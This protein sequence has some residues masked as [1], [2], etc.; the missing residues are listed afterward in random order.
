M[1]TSTKTKLL[2]LM[3]VSTLCVYNVNA[4]TA[5]S[6]SGSNTCG[7]GNAGGSTN[8]S[9][10][11]VAG[12]SNTTGTKNTATGDSALYSNTVSGNSAFGFCSMKLNTTGVSNDATGTNSM[13][14][15]STGTN[16]SAHGINAMFKNTT[17]SGN[18]STG[19]NALYSNA[20]SNYST[21]MGYETLENTTGTY[22]TGF[23]TA[24][25][26]T[27]T[28]GTDNTFVGGLAD[29]N[30]TGY[31]DCGSFGY[32]TVVTASDKI[33][34][35]DANVLGCYNVA[36]VWAAQSDKRFKT[37]VKEDVK[38]LS[39][40]K[41]LRP[42][43][44]NMD[45][46]KLTEF[47]T[48]GMSD[49][50]RRTHLEGKD[51]TESTKKIHAGFIAQEVEQ[52]AKEVGFTSS[53]IVLAPS[54]EHDPYALNYIEFVVP[55]V[56]AVQEQQAMIEQ[57]QQQINDLKKLVAGGVTPAN[58][59]GTSSTT[60]IN[61]QN[62][63]LTDA[64]VLNQNQPNPFAEQTVINYSIPQNASTAQILFYDLNGK[65][66]KTQTITTKGKGALNV[67]ASDLSNG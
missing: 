47:I 5:L 42:V 3:A 9:V 55:L 57:Q 48:E 31:T 24:A 30:G 40:I 16:N 22:N 54:N 7:A 62:I 2:T 10:G 43:T 17:G 29:A 4:Q 23:G 67:Y 6:G 52:V 60:G 25:G 50:A 38:G 15:N 14:S 27:N 32:N 18:T 49:E 26:R 58:P 36:N 53:T 21:A 51:F 35:G 19:F 46:K 20:T 11:C 34:F 13:Y 44:Y 41:K 28:T 56:K 61:A 8:T 65:Q 45:T 33:F 37:N 39:F 12:S 63:E 64:V 1:K 59:N 66:I